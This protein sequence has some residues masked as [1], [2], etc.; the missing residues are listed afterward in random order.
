[1]TEISRERN[2]DIY[3][4][5][6]SGTNLLIYAGYSFPKHGNRGLHGVIKQARNKAC[7]H[8]ND[9]KAAEKQ[10]CR[11]HEKIT[12][13]V[14]VAAQ[15]VAASI[16]LARIAVRHKKRFP[17]LPVEPALENGRPCGKICA[18][19]RG[20][21]M[22]KANQTFVCGPVRLRTSAAQPR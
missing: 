4:P 2:F 20:R 15:C 18:A 3:P 8:G 10:Q 11:Q 12:D 13:D 6:P 19:A 5:L 22:Q 21:G 16:R 9:D 1:M 7:E 17:L 14:V